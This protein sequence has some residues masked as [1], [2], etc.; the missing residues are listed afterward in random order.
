MLGKK[1]EQLGLSPVAVLRQAGLPVG[2][3]NESKSWVTTEELF[4]LHSAIH[5][6]STDPGKCLTLWSEDNIE[7][8]DP[9]AI[10]SL[11]AHSFGDALDRMA[12]YKRFVCPEEIRVVERG[13]ECS[14]QF[15]WLL[16]D[17]EEP[18]T[19]IDLC[20]AWV[21]KIGRLGIGN[22]FKPL[23]IEFKRA[24]SNRKLYEDHFGCI[25]KFGSRHNK[26]IFHR[27]D[28]AKPFRTH[29]PELLEMVLPQLDYELMQQCA[30]RSMKEQAKRIVKM[31]LAGRK[32]RLED[33]A[34]ELRIS[35]RTLQRRLLDE[36]ITFQKLVEEVR[37]ELG[38][39]YLLQPS[40]ELKQIAYLLGYE[41]S[42]SFIRAFHKWEGVSPGEWR[43]TC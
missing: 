36:Q 19:L 13:N 33:V 15:V 37:W 11:C 28:L 29:N 38:R 20:F 21:I 12:R 22:S 8:Y 35:A 18:P 16:A 24:E 27:K 43:S 32:P 40:L 10:A 41:D 5:K 23:R 31:L 7:R 14:V 17:K 1:L 3:L 39:H 42:N 4:A 30:D 26:M 2:L 25:V 9:I 6:L 34:S